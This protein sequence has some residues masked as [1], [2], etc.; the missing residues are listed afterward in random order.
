MLLDW[1][2]ISKITNYIKYITFASKLNIVKIYAILPL[3]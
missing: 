3:R 1:V 2:A